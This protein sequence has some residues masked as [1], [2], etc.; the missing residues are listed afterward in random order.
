MDDIYLL[1]GYPGFIASGL[2]RQLIEDHK[3]NI[4]HIYLLVLPHEVDR[5]YEALNSI[6]QHV[7]R[8][9]NLFTIITGDITKTNLGLNDEVNVT[10][11]TSVT[12][13]FHLAAIY[14]LA[15][16]KQIAYRV[17]VK[18][19]NE[20]NN[21]VLRLK[22]LKRYIYF[23]T[24]YV[25]GTREGRIYE[26]ELNEGQTFKNHYEKTK[27]VAEILVQK[28]MLDIPTTIIRPGIV[29]GHSK[30][31][32]TSKFDGLYFMLNCFD[33]LRFL[34]F[35][36]YFGDGNAEG[37]FVPI[38][39]VLKATSYLSTHRIGEG[40]TYHVTNPLPHSMHDMQKM[41]SEIYL[42][43]RPKGKISVSLVRSLLTI[44][45]IRKWLH[46]ERQAIDYLTIQSS[47]DCTQTIRD[48]N[49]TTISCPPFNQIVEA[50]VQFYRHY[51]DDNTKQIRII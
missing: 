17:N 48:L 26:H 7:H 19:T 33:R 16:S 9:E 10:L 39:Y 11:Q 1:T 40:K 3:N 13:V 29:I 2:L 31:G 51:K 6:G 34:P 14:D 21:W 4:E 46:V 45:L 28:I 23:S 27:Y 24:A 15:V 37:N 47:Y 25:S 41:L 5:A 30:T 43:K 50:I 32:E 12:H 35:F 49:G 38:D 42:H 36:P 20:M 22:N 18:G 44:P 8:N